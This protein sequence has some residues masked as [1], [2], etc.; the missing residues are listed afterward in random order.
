[1]VLRSVF[2]FL[3]FFFTSDD[4]MFAT[5]SA[6]DLPPYI[7][8]FTLSW[9]T[10]TKSS[11]LRFNLQLYLCGCCCI[12]NF[13]CNLSAV[14]SDFFGILHFEWDFNGWFQPNCKYFP[15]FFFKQSEFRVEISGKNC[16]ILIQLINLDSHRS[17]YVMIYITRTT[18]L[19][20][21]EEVKQFHMIYW[22]YMI[23]IEYVLKY[24]KIPEKLAILWQ[25]DIQSTEF[26]EKKL[27]F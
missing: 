15:D 9:K 5:F 17:Y 12:F 26:D 22:E 18:N 8:L 14:L 19:I 13:W 20:I 16:F 7:E 2:F 10:T 3:R 6:T 21:Y 25:M 4:I 24:F 1:M 27:F 11:H 23:K